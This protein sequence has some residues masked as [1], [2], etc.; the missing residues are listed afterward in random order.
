MTINNILFLKAIWLQ[1]L[2]LFKMFASQISGD[3]TF[4]NECLIYKTISVQAWV[5]R[6][7][8]EQS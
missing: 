3:P 2:F 7:D 6:S 5:F 1:I 8:F 4:F